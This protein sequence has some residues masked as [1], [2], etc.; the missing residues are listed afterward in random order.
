MVMEL[1]V[2]LLTR[3]VFPDVAVGPFLPAN[4]ATAA[5]WSRTIIFDRDEIE[6]VRQGKH[7]VRSAKQAIGIGLSQARRDE[8]GH[9]VQ[10]HSVQM[11]AKE[12]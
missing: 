10:L 11:S 8:V 12:S 7:G 6:E 1:Y 9:C 3:L 4:H 2:L 5:S